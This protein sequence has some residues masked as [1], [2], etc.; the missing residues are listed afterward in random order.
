MDFSEME[1]FKAFADAHRSE[2]ES[3]YEEED[4]GEILRNMWREMGEEEKNEWRT[5]SSNKK[6]KSISYLD[7]FR[8]TVFSHS[9]K[10]ML[11]RDPQQ[12]MEDFYLKINS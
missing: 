7:P 11:Y 1:R 9:V 12:L 10:Q 5:P 6:K 4:S 2:V 8:E 3:K